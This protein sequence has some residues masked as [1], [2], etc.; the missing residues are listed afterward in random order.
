MRHK[1]LTMLVLVMVV[2]T[3]LAFQGSPSVAKSNKDVVCPKYTYLPDLQP[4]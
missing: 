3:A 4:Q 1:Q 2:L